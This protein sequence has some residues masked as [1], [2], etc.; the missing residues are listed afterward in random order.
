MIILDAINILQIEGEI[1]K[2][3]IKLAYKK[4]ASKYHPDKGGS[5]EMMQ[6]IN[7]AYDALK[8]HEGD[9]TELQATNTQYSE[10]LHAAIS[11]IVELNGLEL[12][13]CGSWVW[14]SGNTREHKEILK[15]AG[16]KYASKKKMWNYRPAEWKSRSKGSVAIDDIRKKYGSDKA[17]AAR[18]TRKKIAA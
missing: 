12:E 1:T 6:A 9:Y 13:I 16:Y 2:E 14:V 11:A 18:F 4:A 3:T 10:E 8:A 17:K 7:N 5:T 15:A